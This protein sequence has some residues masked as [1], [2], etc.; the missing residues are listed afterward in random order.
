MKDTVKIDK[1]T[2]LVLYSLF[3]VACITGLNVFLNGVA[4]VPGYQGQVDA[5]VDN[6]LRFLSVFWVG[7]GIFCLSVARELDENR[8]FIPYIALLFFL[9]GIGRLASF[10]IVGKPVVLFVGVMSLELFVPV[11]LYYMHIDF[12]RKTPVK[13]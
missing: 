13:T 2:K 11:I 7:F 8:H 5:S 4:S 10:I 6:E 3:G 9:S 12:K 1:A